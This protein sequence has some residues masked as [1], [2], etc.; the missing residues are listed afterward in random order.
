MI[1]QDFF[2]EFVTQTHLTSYGGCIIVIVLAS[3]CTVSLS[4]VLFGSGMEVRKSDGEHSWRKTNTADTLFIENSKLRRQW[5]SISVRQLGS[6]TYAMKRRM[7]H[8]ILKPYSLGKYLSSFLL[9]AQRKILTRYTTIDGRKK[10]P[11]W[12]SSQWRQTHYLFEVYGLSSQNKSVST[13]WRTVKS[14]WLYPRRLLII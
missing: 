3:R 5:G 7:L 1:T 11:V 10:M 8:F 2:L 4:R 12:W 9:V 6:Q 13:S 14:R